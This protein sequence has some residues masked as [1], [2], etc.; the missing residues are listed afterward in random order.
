MEILEIP[1]SPPRPHLF[2]TANAKEMSVRGNAAK[3]DA[4]KRR[5]E[6]IAK[7]NAIP[8]LPRDEDYR[9]KRLARVRTQL[10]KLDDMFDQERDPQK[11]DR[12]ASAQARLAKQEQEL[13][14]RP[15]PG[16]RRPARER[17]AR[18]SQTTAQPIED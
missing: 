3:A 5:E 6:L 13:A 2:T 12:L 11:L 8:S 10:E 16:S 9:L 14:G 7:A 18:P 1:A 17:P 4:K 15:L